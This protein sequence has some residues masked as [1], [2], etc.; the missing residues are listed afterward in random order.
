MKA[1]K[2][3]TKKLKLYSITVSGQGD[4][5]ITLVTKEIWDWVHD[6]FGIPIPQD[7]IDA[8]YE[9][10]D[11]EPG[12]TPYISGTKEKPNSCT[13]NDAALNA[14]GV[15]IDG[16]RASFVTMRKFTKF[17]QKYNIEIVDEWEGY[18]Y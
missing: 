11:D 18:I 10:E 5:W 8:H 2:A 9:D 3:T 17:I 14:P 16:K 4:T 6:P 15:K 7:V 12:W 13:Y 1:N